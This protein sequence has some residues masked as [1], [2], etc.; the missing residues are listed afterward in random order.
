MIAA[1]MLDAPSLGDV[2]AW[3]FCKF[4]R[5]GK[6]AIGRFAVE[7]EEV[8]RVLADIVG[9][10]RAKEAAAMAAFYL[11]AAPVD[12]RLDWPSSQFLEAEGRRVDMGTVSVPWDAVEP[13]LDVM[14][15]NYDH[16]NEL[17]AAVWK[18]VS[19][20]GPA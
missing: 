18:A 6:A 3:G 16:L 2:P 11:D 10:R 13:V 14:R 17:R 15:A 9:Q 7:N 4:T 5:I 19:R 8:R 12:R 20:G 1:P